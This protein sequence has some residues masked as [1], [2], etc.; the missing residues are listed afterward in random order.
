MQ[1][2]QSYVERYCLGL[3][4]EEIG[5]ALCHVG[6]AYRFGYDTPEFKSENGTD[7]SAQE[8][9]HKELGDVQAAI[10]FASM[11]RLIDPNKVAWYSYR[12]T[13]KLYDESKKDNLGRPL[14]PQPE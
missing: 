7:V 12:K 2:D 11:H 5:E 13:L 3:L 6:R 1:N 8:L 10:H 14:A 4:V 9:L